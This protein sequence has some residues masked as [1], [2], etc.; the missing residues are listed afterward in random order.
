MIKVKL[1]YMSFL[2]PVLIILNKKFSE[3]LKN[4][5]IFNKICIIFDIH[6]IN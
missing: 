6:Q 3:K 1:L 5:L 2:Y 4:N